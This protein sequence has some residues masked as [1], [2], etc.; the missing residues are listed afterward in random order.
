MTTISRNFRLAIL[1]LPAVLVIYEMMGSVLWLHTRFDQWIVPD[2][3]V[4]QL[5]F[6]SFAPVIYWGCKPALWR[7]VYLIS[8]IGLGAFYAIALTAVA[9]N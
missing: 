3:W 9:F 2:L 7:K 6:L 1:L 4:W 8:A 5:L